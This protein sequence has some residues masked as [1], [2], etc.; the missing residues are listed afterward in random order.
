MTDFPLVFAAGH[1]EDFHIGGTTCNDGTDTGDHRSS[2]PHHR[3][4]LVKRTNAQEALNYLSL[5]RLIPEE[6]LAPQ[7]QTPPPP[8]NARTTASPLLVDLSLLGP[9]TPPL[10]QIR[11][12]KFK[13]Y[14][15]S[16]SPTTT[17]WSDGEER[18]EDTDVHLVVLS[19]AST[20]QERGEDETP[21]QQQQKEQVEFTLMN[22][23]GEV[24][25]KAQQQR[26][27]SCDGEGT[28]EEARWNRLLV[29]FVKSLERDVELQW[30]GQ[31]AALPQSGCRSAAKEEECSLDCPMW[32]EVSIELV[33]VVADAVVGHSLTKTAMMHH[34]EQQQQQQQEGLVVIVL[35]IKI[36]K[37]RHHPRTSDAKLAKILK[38]EQGALVQRNGVRL[39][40]GVVVVVEE[41]RHR[42]SICPCEGKN[43]EEREKGE[44]EQLNDPSPISA[45]S[46]SSP[47]SSYRTEALGKDI[48][49]S[50]ETTEELI[51]YLEQ[52]LKEG[53]RTACG[54]GGDCLQEAVQRLHASVHSLR[55]TVATFDANAEQLDRFIFVSTSLLV[56]VVMRG[57]GEG[58]GDGPRGSASVHWI[59]W[60]RSGARE[61][62][63]SEAEIGFRDGLETIVHV[64]D[65]LVLRTAE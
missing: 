12:R 29:S 27:L 21:Q 18:V 43:A 47:S 41:P 15:D 33:D 63:F 60:A 55:N 64:V 34:Q 61:R 51:A 6:C 7:E 10:L 4:S 44:M 31:E 35:D 2:S 65:S 56:T 23:H 52:L 57:G 38:K 50:F 40:G 42:T 22:A 36:G 5:N 30:K 14:H 11:C 32:G 24:L 16:A 62:N 26:A 46:S 53:A 8:S 59:D 1:R 28:A 37:L 48:G 54:G 25:T 20:T 13:T 19:L 58:G 45:A 9:W 3:R 17:R 39:C 49:H